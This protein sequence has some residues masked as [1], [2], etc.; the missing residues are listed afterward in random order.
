MSTPEKPQLNDET[1]DEAELSETE[2]ESVNGGSKAIRGVGK[3]KSSYVVS[4]FALDL[5]SDSGGYLKKE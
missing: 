1:K 3:S 5:E 4:N 2:L